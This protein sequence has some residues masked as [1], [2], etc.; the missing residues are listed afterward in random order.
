[1]SFCEINGEAGRSREQTRTT[2]LFRSRASEPAHWL[3]LLCSALMAVTACMLRGACGIYVI[4]TEGNFTPRFVAR[5]NYTARIA[6]R[7]H[8]IV[9]CGGI[10]W[11]TYRVYRR[12]HTFAQVRRQT[13]RYDISD[14]PCHQRPGQ[15]LL[16]VNAKALGDASLDPE[17]IRRVGSLGLN[18]TDIYRNGG[19][20]TMV[21]RVGLNCELQPHLPSGSWASTR[22]LWR[23]HQGRARA[24]LGGLGRCVYPGLR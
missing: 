10:S 1:M 14:E 16:L 13:A 4:N 7:Y 9:G 3:S 19:G 6:C 22:G 2:I 15:L 24:L 11:S 18:A 5:A 8:S 20:D 21:S 12:S 23:T 17:A